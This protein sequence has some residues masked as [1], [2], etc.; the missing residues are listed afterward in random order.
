MKIT[1]FQKYDKNVAKSG[2]QFGSMM[3]MMKNI[4]GE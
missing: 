1:I 2:K 4:F 3:N